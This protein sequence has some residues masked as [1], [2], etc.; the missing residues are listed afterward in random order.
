M[1]DPSNE[2]TK[3]AKSQ[4]IVQ[5]YQIL[6]NKEQ[7]NFINKSKLEIARQLQKHSKQ[8]E[9]ALSVSLK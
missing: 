5:G 9:E 3:L 8:S 6:D 7:L 2:I 1:L 4:L